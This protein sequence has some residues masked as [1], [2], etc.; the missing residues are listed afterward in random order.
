[1]G[2]I[3]GTDFHCKHTILACHLNERQVYGDQTMHKNKNKN[4]LNEWNG[5]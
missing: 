4:K 1:M 2:A 5:L 3:L